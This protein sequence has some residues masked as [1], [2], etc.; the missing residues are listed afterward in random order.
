MQW[1][2]PKGFIMT[3]AKLDFRPDGLFH[4]CMRTPDGK[5]MWG[6][7]VYR[8]IKAPE[9]ILW[10][11]SFSD[12]QG[13]V[14]RHPFS[15]MRWPLQILSEATFTEREGKTTVA[16]RWMPLD[17]TQEERKTFDDGRGSMT[18]GWTGTFDQLAAFIG[19]E[20]AHPGPHSIPAN[21]R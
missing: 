21:S 13:G 4:Y 5:E 17:A 14:T 16:I 20:M 6:K 8:E 15:D 19:K 9:R 2:G 12:P 3:T 7:F 10:V 1:F 18:Q 11:N